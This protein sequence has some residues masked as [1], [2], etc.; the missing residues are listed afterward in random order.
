MYKNFHNLLGFDFDFFVNGERISVQGTKDLNIAKK[1]LS[2]VDFANVG[3]QVK[4]VDFLNYYQKFFAVIGKS[5][6][7][8]EQMQ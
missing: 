1:N 3:S 2:S 6:N 7:Y 8:G 5:A 4:Y